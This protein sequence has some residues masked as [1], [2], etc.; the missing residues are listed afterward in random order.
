MVTIED[1][2]YA[3]NDNAVEFTDIDSIR[4]TLVGPEGTEV[5]PVFTE[6]FRATTS[7]DNRVHQSL[8]GQTEVEGIGESSWRITMEGLVLQRQLDKLF[9]LR[10][11]N[12]R[13]KV[14]AE[15]RTHTN[16]TF[17]RFTYEQT[18]ELNEGNFSY[19]GR[20][21]TEPLFRFQ[22]QTQDDSSL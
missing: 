11:A 7:N 9:D 6:T 3:A 12:N 1:I 4:P 18:D 5:T 10:P 20:E 21:V 13:I 8:C 16:V 19:N 15:A 2:V 17:D 22:L 14:I